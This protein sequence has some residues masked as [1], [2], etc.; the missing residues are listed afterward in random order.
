MLGDGSRIG[1]RALTVP[2]TAHS[3]VVAVTGGVT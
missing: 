3:S 2:L 1:S